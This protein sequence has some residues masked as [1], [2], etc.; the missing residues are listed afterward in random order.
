MERI[1]VTK[2]PS[3]VAALTDVIDSLVDEH[4]PLD[5]IILLTP[6]NDNSEWRDRMRLGDY[7]LVRSLQHPGGKH[8]CVESI[9]AFKGLERPVVILAELDRLPKHIATDADRDSLLYVALSRARN[10]VIVLGALPEPTPTT[11]H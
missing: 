2:Y 5:H 9:Q 4:V 11:G 7:T 3:K 10:H 8:I 1:D 6:L